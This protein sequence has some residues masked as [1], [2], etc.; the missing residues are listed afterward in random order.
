MHFCAFRH[1][2]PGR[3]RRR[4]RRYATNSTGAGGGAAACGGRAAVG[5]TVSLI[6]ILQITPPLCSHDLIGLHSSLYNDLHNEPI[7]INISIYKYLYIYISIYIRARKRIYSCLGISADP[8]F[9][10][11]GADGSPG[12]AGG[13]DSEGISQHGEVRPLN[14]EL[15][16]AAVSVLLALRAPGF[17]PRSLLRRFF[18][19]VQ[20]IVLRTDIRVGARHCCA[21]RVN[22]TAVRPAWPAARD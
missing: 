3:R 10:D 1:S 15:D 18:G 14:K 2:G 19:L 8:Y 6:H 13:I 9:Y 4:R 11:L 5:G 20:N 17:L 7:R 22:P 12:V 21:A 16:L